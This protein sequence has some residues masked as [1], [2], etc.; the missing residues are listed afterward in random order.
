MLPGRSLCDFSCHGSRY[1]N[2]SRSEIARTTNK[3]FKWFDGDSTFAKC[4]CD[5]F[6]SVIDA[7]NLN[8]GEKFKYNYFFL[9]Y[10]EEW[11]LRH[12][13]QTVGKY[14]FLLFEPINAHILQ[15][16]NKRVLLIFC[17]HVSNL[18]YILFSN[19]ERTCAQVTCALVLSFIAAF[20]IWPA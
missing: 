14:K 1:I 2:V 17:I 11:D 13:W 16:I 10:F 5:V 15:F 6:L 8:N 3:Q 7:T 20:F 12:S 4:I 18:E 9:T 19:I